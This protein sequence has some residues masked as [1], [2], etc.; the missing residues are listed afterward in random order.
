VMVFNQA[1]SFSNLFSIFSA[2]SGGITIAPAIADQPASITKYATLSA[3]LGVV[4]G[5]S[6]T[7][8]YQWQVSSN[9]IAGSFT[10]VLTAGDI[11]G[12]QSATLSFTNL[13]TNDT[14]QY[15]VIVTNTLGAVTSSIATVTVIPAS[16]YAKAVLGFGP[17]AFYELNE[18]NSPASSNAVAYD[19]VGGYNGLYGP[20]VANG[21]PADNAVAGP[22]A[23]NGFPGFPATQ[24]A[25]EFTNGDA[26]SVI[27]LPPWT[28]PNGTNMTFTAWIYPFAQPGTVGL[29]FCRSNT[30]VAGVDLESS[31][32]PE[33][34]LAYNWNNMQ[35]ASSFATGLLP[36]SNQWSF[37]VVEVDPTNASFYLIN[38]NGYATIN[39]ALAHV[40]QPFD[41]V[42][43]L[44]DDTFSSAA[45]VFSGEMAEVAV[46][47]SSLTAAQVK[48]LY[49][50]ASGVAFGPPVISQ[51]PTNLTLP[52]GSYAL[53][54]VVT[55]GG[56]PPPTYQWAASLY[57]NGPYFNLTDG[58]Q[59][60]GSATASLSISNLV[61]SNTLNYIVYV[62]N[63]SGTVTSSVASL[64]VTPLPVPG[65]TSISLSGANLLINGTNGAAGLYFITLTSTNAAQALA[66][67]K[68]VAT[69]ALSAN[70]AF[71]I[72]ATNAVTAGSPKQFYILLVQ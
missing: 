24:Y 15:M 59:F 4:A 28:F 31:A 68:P 47:N 25:A 52:S 19:Y 12:P 53:F 48:S 26:N 29:I 2:A 43:L 33:E 40:S 38:T 17:Y 49:T 23:A 37:V 46:F 58:G 8:N 69:N 72:T 6:K 34:P 63:G 22:R 71:N 18:T 67:W 50:N 36:P 30:T 66:T 41:G 5:S 57:T 3:Q 62:A 65:I 27:G 54:T 61:A 51:Q 16:M 11:I 32:N 42:T 20:D 7:V 10:N 45:R 9:G 13:S 14:G 64:T 21:S 55:S 60:L 56:F 44:G 39:Q 1:L 35:S 70:G